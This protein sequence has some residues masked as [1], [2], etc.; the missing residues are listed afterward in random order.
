M[1]PARRDVVFPGATI[2]GER[3]IWVHGRVLL[4]VVV[5]VVVVMMMSSR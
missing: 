2:V 3:A 4:V 1:H 5:V